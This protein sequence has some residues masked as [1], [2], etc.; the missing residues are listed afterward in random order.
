MNL[1]EIDPLFTSRCAVLC[2]IKT[3]NILKTED[4]FKYGFV[5]TILVYCV[6][7]SGCVHVFVFCSTMQYLA[8]HWGRRGRVIE[9]A[10]Y[11]FLLVVTY[12]DSMRVSPLYGGMLYEQSG[13][14]IS[15][16]ASIG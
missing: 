16:V 2:S 11:G 3:L 9:G 4:E 12:C 13:E 5:Y 6:R 8:E 7:F 15:Y 10:V 14:A 1:C